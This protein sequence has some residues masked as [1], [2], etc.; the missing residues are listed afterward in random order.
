MTHVVFPVSN[1]C[2]LLV[3]AGT[4]AIRQSIQTMYQQVQVL[5]KVFK[6]EALITVIVRQT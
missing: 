2:W 5:S 4:G 3:P 1:N 6:S